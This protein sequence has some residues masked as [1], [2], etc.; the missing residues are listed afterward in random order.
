M[1]EGSEGVREEHSDIPLENKR[2]EIAS[3]N[4]SS[5]TH[6]RDV[7]RIFVDKDLPETARACACDWNSRS[8]RVLRSVREIESG[9]TRC[10]GGGVA[11]D[12]AADGDANE[13]AAAAR[14][15][16]PD[17]APPC[18]ACCHSGSP[19]ASATSNA[20]ATIKGR[21][22]VRKGPPE[23]GF[24]AIKREMFIT[25]AHCWPRIVPNGITIT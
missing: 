21:S 23:S 13:G 6:R 2:G 10:R 14:D 4:I 7:R 16:P 1:R 22:R 15:R 18:P 9:C 24:F 19:A 5:V 3:R 17:D 20:P 25:R 12:G 11:T 8:R